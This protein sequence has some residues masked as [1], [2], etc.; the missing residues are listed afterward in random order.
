MRDNVRHLPVRRQDA[1]GIHG[2][3][4]PVGITFHPE[5]DFETWV[6]DGETIKVLHGSLAWMVSDWI[7]EGQKRWGEMYAQA[8]GDYYSPETLRTYRYVAERFPIQR[9]RL[10]LFFGH[11]QAV[12]RLDPIEQDEVLD[13]AEKHRWSRTLTR[14]E[15]KRRVDVREEAKKAATAKR[16]PPMDLGSGGAELGPE[17]D[18]SL[19]IQGAAGGAQ[20]SLSEGGGEPAHEPDVRDWIGSS[21]TLREVQED[22]ARGLPEVIPPG[23]D[24]MKADD[25]AAMLRSVAEAALP[26]NIARA[27]F[28][29]LDERE[30]LLQVFR[31]ARTSVDVGHIT[32]ALSAAVEDLSKEA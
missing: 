30:R 14:E 17:D 3:V 13:L 19:D 27:V 29:L 1:S 10:S 26:P 31:A 23:P 11:H 21:E 6:A 18:N 20:A 12:A 7:L 16:E 8:I 9:R 15:V 32:A 5:L 4:T 24:P 2:Q 28:A 22:F 25:A